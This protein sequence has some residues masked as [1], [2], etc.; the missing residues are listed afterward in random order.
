[1]RVDPRDP[2]HGPQPGSHEGLVGL[3]VRCADA[4]HV[5]RQAEHPSHLDDFVERRDLRLEAFDGVAVLV[6]E[7]D[8]DQPSKACP[9]ATGSSKAV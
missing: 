1:V 3:E 8:V 2:R 5:V 7:V 4:H 6:R 9:I